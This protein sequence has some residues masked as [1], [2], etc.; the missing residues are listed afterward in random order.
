MTTAGMAG[1]AL[2]V[3]PAYRFRESNYPVMLEFILTLPHISKGAP[4][5]VGP[6]KRSERFGRHIYEGRTIKVDPTDRSDV[7]R[8]NELVK[9]QVLLSVKMFRM[10]AVLEL[11]LIEVEQQPEQPVLAPLPPI[12]VA[13]A[14][15]VMVDFA[16]NRP[17]PEDG[18]VQSEETNRMILEGM[19]ADT[20]P[21][22]GAARRR[23]PATVATS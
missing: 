20:V 1:L 13:T 6:Y 5:K 8:F 14:E 16:A 7:I 19:Q 12:V 21:P 11:V 3:G 22:M 18:A 2:V 15:P 9:R 10:P 4:G 17:V 23:K